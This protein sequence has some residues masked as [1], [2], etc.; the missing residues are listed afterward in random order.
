MSN[1]KTFQPEFGSNGAVL[2]APTMTPEMRSEYEQ[3]ASVKQIILRTLPF[4]LFLLAMTGMQLIF[5]PPYGPV[6]IG[7]LAAFV[8]T[9]LLAPASKRGRDR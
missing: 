1:D 2:N 9:R 8:G 7:I 4:P 5:K 6:W 3:E